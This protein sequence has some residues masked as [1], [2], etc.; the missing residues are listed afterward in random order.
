MCVYIRAY[1]HMLT[2]EHD[3]EINN[4]MSMTVIFGRTNT[5]IIHTHTNTYI[6]RHIHIYVYA[7]FLVS[8]TDSF[9]NEYMKF[10]FKEY[11]MQFPI[12]V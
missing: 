3:V 7:A 2:Y 9:S 12:S 10:Y 5:Y 6:H 8:I 4:I 1:V 11:T